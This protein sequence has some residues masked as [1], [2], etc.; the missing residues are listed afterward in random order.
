MIEN[1]SLR[2]SERNCLE[3]LFATSIYVAIEKELKQRKDEIDRQTSTLTQ[4]GTDLL[5]KAEVSTPEELSSLVDELNAAQVAATAERDRLQDLMEQVSKE[6]TKAEEINRAFDEIEK[7]EARLAQL[8]GQQAHIDRLVTALEKHDL[9]NPLKPLHEFYTRALTALPGA[10]QETQAASDEESR[11]TDE[12]KVAKANDQLAK[13][14]AAVRDDLLKQRLNWRS[15]T[16]LDE[17][18]SAA[19]VLKQATT[20]AATA[21]THLSLSRPRLSASGSKAKSRMSKTARKLKGRTQL[22]GAQSELE[23]R[24]FEGSGCRQ[25][26]I[27]SSRAPTGWA[28]T[29]YQRQPQPMKKTTTYTSTQQKWHREA[30]VLAATRRRHPARCVAARITRHRLLGENVSG[31]NWRQHVRLLRPGRPSAA[32]ANTANA[33]ETLHKAV[34]RWPRLMR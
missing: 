19:T 1:Y 21:K 25:D 2:T 23:G 26:G 5:E 7:A 15:T 13:D 4:R 22:R 8:G 16:S 11:L 32:E 9:A 27:R 31:T 18:E 24:K 28:E 3:K 33:T 34:D 12:L 29:A 20:T 10:E 6:K 14:N 30:A 17:L